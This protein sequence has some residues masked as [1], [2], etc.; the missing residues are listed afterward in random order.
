V[1]V[2]RCMGARSDTL[3][4][5][6]REIR[7]HGMQRR[8]TQVQ[9]IS[10]ARLTSRT[11]KDV[12]VRGAGTEAKRRGAQ[13]APSNPLQNNEIDVR[14]PASVD[15][16][17]CMQGL[18]CGGSTANH[19]CCRPM[20][21]VHANVITVSVIDQCRSSIGG[22]HAARL[23]SL[24]EWHEHWWHEESSTAPGRTRSGPS[25]CYTVCLA[26]ITPVA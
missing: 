2:M 21:S 5:P 25:R 13:R 14:E 1:T 6:Q 7:Q 18:R 15:W 4:A 12:P 20:T 23:S 22:V 26:L 3:N 8:P 17:E 11:G 19:A 16:N 24:G 9:R 10:S